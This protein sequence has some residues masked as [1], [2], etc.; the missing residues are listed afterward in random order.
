[1]NQGKLFS[2]MYV[3]TP[4]GD[5]ATVMEFVGNHV[6][7]VRHKDGVKRLFLVDEVQDATIKPKGESRT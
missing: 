7:V 2:G 5:I 6:K 4:D 1:M 3:R